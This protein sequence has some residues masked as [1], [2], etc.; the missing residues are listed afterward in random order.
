MTGAQ[1]TAAAAVLSCSVY[2][3]PL[4]GPHAAWLLGEVVYRE[5][6]NLVRG[7]AGREAAWVA[8]DLAVALVAQ[9]AFGLLLY[10]F[11]GRPGW[12][13][14]LVVILPVFPAI[15]LLNY[16]YQVAI[17][18]RFLI[19]PDTTPERVAWPL[20]CTA[21]D[22]WIPQLGAPIEVRAAAAAPLW[23]AETAPPLRYALL[24]L[25]GCKVTPL[26]LTQSATGYVTYVA[27]GRALYTTLVPAT[28]R[29][30]WSVFDVATGR[31]TPLA[32]DPG[33]VPILSTDGRFAAWLRPVAGSTPPVELEAVVRGVDRPGERVVGLA[34]VG[35]GALQQVVEADTAAGELVVARGLREFL[36]VG[37]DGRLRGTGPDFRGVVDP[38]PQTVKLLPGGWVAWDAY[39][40]NAAY[41]VAWSLPRG[42]GLHRVP[43]GRGVTSL[44]V[45][46]D[47]RFIA[48]SVTSG[49][50][51]G[52]TQDAVYALDTATGA[53]VFRKYFPKYT[54]ASLAFPGPRRFLYTDL[55]G[56]NVLRIP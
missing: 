18:M 5:L 19:E 55:G 31:L 49:L 28:G 38:Q 25:P 14:G 40:E 6:A 17:P 23:V 30:T 56:V 39:R 54:R 48:L 16:V 51:I 7:R 36:R 15:V 35:R 13:R 11:A 24:E 3:T 37:L 43:K 12:L 2:L 21:R 10:W 53:E 33:Q 9:F 42:Q 26:E 44:A 27:E 32:V 41:R 29:Q 52:S 47:G 1:R 22:V 45:S 50:S 20:E 4:V 46:P 34:A 8:A